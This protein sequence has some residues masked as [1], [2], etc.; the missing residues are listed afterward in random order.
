MSGNFCGSFGINSKLGFAPS[1]PIDAAPVAPTSRLEILGENFVYS[2]QIIGGRGLNGS[3]NEITAHLRQGQ[4]MV[5]GGFVCEVG[6][7]ELAPFIRAIC[8]NTAADQTKESFDQVPFDFTIGRDLVTHAY[9]YC[10]PQQVVIRGRSNPEDPEDQILQMAMQFMGVEEHTATFPGGLALPDTDRL[11]W[12]IGD[13]KLEVGSDDFPIIGFDITIRNR[14]QPLFRNQLKPG[15]FRMLGRRIT[16][17]VQVPYSSASAAALFGANEETDLTLS[18]VSDNLPDDFSD[19][20][21]VVN[22][23]SVRRTDKQATTQGRGEIPLVATFSA[24]QKGSGTTM[25]ITNEITAAP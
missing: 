15:C 2:D 6:P 7:N 1:G 21:T 17:E 22:F 12:L 3:V 9:R 13:S 4:R 23:P 19:Y 18:L 11:Y 25:S 10:I 24:Y 16:I 14:L 5:S 8:G 20:S